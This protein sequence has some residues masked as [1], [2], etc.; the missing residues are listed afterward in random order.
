M[1][2]NIPDV[3]LERYR[4]KEL[5]ETSARAVE[6]M[7][8]A[9]PALR[10]RLEALERSDVE[11]DR[12]YASR[13]VIHDKPAPSRRAVVRFAIAA[14]AGIAALVIAFALPR[15]PSPSAAPEVTRIKGGPSTPALALYR[16]TAA[17][18]E[19]LADGDIV[20]QGDLVRVAYA[21]AGR[22]YGVILSI[23]GRGAVTVHLPPQG[24]RAVPLTPGKITLLDAAY[25]LD[26]APR[27]ERFFLITGQDPFAVAPV[28]D[29]A[30]R[31]AAPGTAPERLP[32]PAGLEQATF[33]IQKEDRQ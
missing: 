18:S 9:D 27:V 30:R 19:R 29:A 23:D 31:A 28:T 20:H 25:E 16:R 17:G 8:A 7:L 14:A 2:R 5:P 21:S 32:L 3:V 22:P 10:A 15:T 11:I 1:T 6:H 4:L 24:D 12:E 33:A 13:I 26:D